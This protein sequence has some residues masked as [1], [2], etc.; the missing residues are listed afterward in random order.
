VAFIGVTVALVALPLLV[1]IGSPAL[2]AILPFV[3]LAI[4]GVWWAL[5]R[6]YRDGAIVEALTLGPTR[7]SL[8]RDGPRGARHEWEANTHWVQ[9]A[10]HA[11]GGPVPHYLT[12]RGGPRE[13]EIGRFLS[14]EERISLARVL[15][16]AVGLARES[17]QG[18]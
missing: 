3:G 11:K 4:W 1:L 14:E 18:V 7:T 10:L 6:S 12:L 15:T 5:M 8:T 2:W 9:V 13:V 17:R 16:E